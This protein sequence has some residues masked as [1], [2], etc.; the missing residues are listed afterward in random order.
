MAAHFAEAQL[1]RRQALEINDNVVQ[2]LVAAVYALEQGQI[3][4]SADY[5]AHTL[6]A[7]R[8]MMD[9][10]LEPLDGEGLRPGDLV[11]A[12]PAVIG[13]ERL[14]MAEGRES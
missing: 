8:A 11:R 3:D 12:A 7:V 2:G 14:T 5:L 9:D 1:K 13:A 6:S 4:R 10:L